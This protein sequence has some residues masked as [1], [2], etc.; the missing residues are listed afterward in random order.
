MEYSLTM[1]DARNQRL[2]GFDNAHPLPGNKRHRGVAELAYDHWHR[3]GKAKPYRY[4]NG[5]KLVADFWEAAD[6][7]LKRRGTAS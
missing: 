7:V 5:A 3:L 6:E 2:I 1:H 4:E